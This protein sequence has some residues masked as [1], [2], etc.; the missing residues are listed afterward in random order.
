M[1]LIKGIVKNYP[2]GGTS[3]LPNL[4]GTANKEQV[5]HAEYWLGSHPDGDAV[6]TNLPQ[7][8]LRSFIKDH[9]GKIFPPNHAQKD[10]GLPFLFK[11]LDV[12]N[13]LSIQ[14]HP[15]K[16]TAM[17]G[18]IK[19]NAQGKSRDAF[20]R[21]YKDG[22]HKP[23]LM[24]ALSEFWLVQGFKS[25]EQILSTLDGSKELA[26]LKSIFIE[27]G[28]A[29]LYRYI[30]QADQATI[31]ALLKPL[32]KRI[33]PQYE[34]GELAKDDINFWAARA[35]IT[36]NQQGKC[37]R[38]ILSLYLMNLVQLKKGEGIY[39]APGVLHA[40]LEGQNVECMANSDNVI[41]GGL[42]PKHIDV[43]L[44][45]ELV[46]FSQDRPIIVHPEQ[47][48]GG[49]E[50]Y[51]TPAQEFV[52]STVTAQP[53]VEIDSS[54][55]NLMICIDG[56][57]EVTATEGSCSLEKGD[58]ILLTVNDHAR[59]ITLQSGQLFVAQL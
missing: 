50:T 20:D 1:Y 35:F 21:V 44:L 5:P 41:R 17:Q 47:Q 18:F 9:P 43:P 55:A 51:Q 49:L 33:K 19:E 53:S 30:M 29:H 3:Y 48:A 57:Y 16:E 38:G 58:A 40:Y 4:L 22:N 15:D 42:T 27:G 46:S 24:V 2:W 11:V 59:I 28:L 45:L 8:T 14:L 54:A 32:G 12:R 7:T 23:E 6:L 10:G 39:Q 36:F 25:T 31:N 37:D 56:A 13:M 34:S 26:S 52:L